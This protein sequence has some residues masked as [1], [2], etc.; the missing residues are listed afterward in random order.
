LNSVLASDFTSGTIDALLSRKKKIQEK[1]AP[2]PP[3][4]KVNSHVEEAETSDAIMTNAVDSLEETSLQTKYT[5]SIDS[6]DVTKISGIFSKIEKFVRK[7][8]PPGSLPDNKTL[9]YGFWANLDENQLLNATPQYPVDELNQLTKLR[10]RMKA[11][12]Q[13]IYGELPV[14]GADLD[15]IFLTWLE[16]TKQ[17]LQ[18]NDTSLLDDTMKL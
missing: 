8:L 12:L 11:F 4:E 7:L 16:S 5:K 18:S 2:S 10:E 15:E 6:T 3:L 13:L 14:E 17:E 9:D 1:R